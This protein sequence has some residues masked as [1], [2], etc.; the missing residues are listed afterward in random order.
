MLSFK[1]GTYDRSPRIQGFFLNGVVLDSTVLDPLLV[2][3]VFPGTRRADSPTRRQP[4]RWKFSSVV[5]SGFSISMVIYPVYG[6]WVWEGGGWPTWG[7]L[8]AW[9]TARRLRPARSWFT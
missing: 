5:V 3:M 4:E 1:W 2:P 9:Q 7:R 8:F 6:C